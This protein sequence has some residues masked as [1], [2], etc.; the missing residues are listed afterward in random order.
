MTS[1]RPSKPT[2]AAK[3]SDSGRGCLSVAAV[4]SLLMVPLL[5]AWFLIAVLRSAGDAPPLAVTFQNES[6]QSVAIARNATGE[7]IDEFFRRSP[8]LF[9]LGPGV[10]VPIRWSTGE[11]Y[12]LCE[13][14]DIEYYVVTLP[15]RPERYIAGQTRLDDF[16]LLETVGPGICWDSQNPTY[17]FSG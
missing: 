8:V 13:H 9:F 17:T 6:D 7:E 11:P 3:P 1:A 12:T 16:N 2:P 15:I 4:G 5:A 10:E 14:A